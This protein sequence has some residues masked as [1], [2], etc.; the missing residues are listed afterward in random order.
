VKKPEIETAEDIKKDIQR[1]EKEI[2]LEIEEI[3]SMR[4]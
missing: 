1:I 2:R 3:K 4:G